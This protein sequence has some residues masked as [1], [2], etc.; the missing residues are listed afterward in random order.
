MK[1]LIACEFTGAM[2]RAFRELGYYAWSCDLL[3]AADN[4]PFHYQCDVRELLHDG[5]DLIIAHPEC[6]YLCNSGVKWLYNGGVK[7][8]GRNEER[9][10]QLEAGVAFYELF[11][12]VDCPHVAIENPVMH[13][14]ALARL[15][16]DEGEVQFV[17]PWWFGDKMF[18]NTGFCLKNLPYLKPTK[19]LKPPRK[20]DDPEEHYKWS[21][22]HMASPGPNRWA[23]RSATPPGLAAACAAQWGAHV[24]QQTS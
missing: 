11:R 24:A 4:S 13:E 19:M 1:V 14:H 20:A 2:R 17:Q 22:V 15:G 3:P 5:W 12:H 16:F 23:I 8:N 21:K 6:T 18:K 10:Q 7:R 9:W